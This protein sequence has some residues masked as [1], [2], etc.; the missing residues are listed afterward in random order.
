MSNSDKPAV[1]SIEQTCFACPS[2]WEG[3]TTE[4]ERLYCRY[5]YGILS[6]SVGEGVDRQVL[7]SRDMGDPWGGVMN[8][9]QLIRH[10]GEVLNWR[11]LK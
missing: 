5:R 10:T 8:L 9:V 11:T 2:Q 1:K 6:V 7:M 4:G 3:K